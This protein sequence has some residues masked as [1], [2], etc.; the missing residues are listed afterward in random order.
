ME[1]E[2]KMLTLMDMD[3]ATVMVIN[4]IIHTI[5]AMDMVTMKIQTNF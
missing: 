1:S 2:R 4:T 5:T 3:M